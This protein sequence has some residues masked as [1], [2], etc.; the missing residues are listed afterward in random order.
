MEEA[1]KDGH[2]QDK[3]HHQGG[4]G[5]IYHGVEV[6]RAADT[7]RKMANADPSVITFEAICT[8]MCD[9]NPGSDYTTKQFKRV[10][11]VVDEV[12]EAGIRIPM[13]HIENSE[14]LLSDLIPDEIFTTLL[15]GQDGQAKT[16]GSL[17]R[18]DVR[19]AEP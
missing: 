4:K 10:Q 16:I 8:H 15:R 6:H 5:N 1:E 19:P 7:I 2:E 12:R 17:G 13:I 11:G 3:G 14:S 18:G 9:A